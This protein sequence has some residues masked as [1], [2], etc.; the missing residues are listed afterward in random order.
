MTHGR[1][2]KRSKPLDLGA[3]Q[4]A[5][6][7]SL[8]VHW[9]HDELLSL[10]DIGAALAA[11]GLDRAPSGFSQA[12]KRVTEY[13][14]P[15]EQLLGEMIRQ[16]RRSLRTIRI[17]PSSTGDPSS[18]GAT[19][20]DVLQEIAREHKERGQDQIT[21]GLAGGRTPAEMCRARR[22]GSGPGRPASMARRPR[23]ASR[24]GSNSAP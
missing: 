2:G 11:R 20:A 5:E 1:G 4:R 19:A 9:Y 22:C 15:A 18:V 16:R 3:L 21:I 14:R 10:A 23:P 12:I 8:I 24:D 17:E 7:N 13:I 6:I